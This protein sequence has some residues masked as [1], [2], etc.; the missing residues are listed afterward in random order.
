MKSALMAQ[1]ALHIACGMDWHGYRNKSPAAGVVYFALER[2]DLVARRIRAHAKRMES[3]DGERFCFDQIPLVVSDATIDLTR[4]DAFRKFIATIR[5]ANA[6]F[7]TCGLGKTELVI[8]DTFAKL[9]AAGGGTKTLRKI[10]ARYS[11]ISSASNFVKTCML[12]WLAT[13]ARMRPEAPEV[14]M[15]SWAT[16]M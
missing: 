8:I 10:R 5:D 15:R 11:R 14:P 4:P 7:E 2:V 3:E 13:P 16:L 9:I 12:P 6:Y 1:A